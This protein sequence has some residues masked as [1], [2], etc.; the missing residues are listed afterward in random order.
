MMVPSTPPVSLIAS[1]AA[2]MPVFGRDASALI[3]QFEKEQES[4]C[5]ENVAAFFR[6][7]TEYVVLL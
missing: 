7:L 2:P 3:D 5:P 6:N 1:W 4:P